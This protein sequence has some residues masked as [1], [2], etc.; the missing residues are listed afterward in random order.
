MKCLFYNFYI[1]P[2]IDFAITQWGQ[3]A[4]T[5][6]KNIQILQN[7]AARIVL[8]ANWEANGQGL[9]DKLGWMN[10]KQRIVGPIPNW[11]I[12]V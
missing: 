10:I 8:N 7:K 3:A 2:H 12:N 9:L 1:L 5:H 6:I 4:E 11:N